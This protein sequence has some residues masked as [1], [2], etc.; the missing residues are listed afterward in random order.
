[1]ARQVHFYGGASLSNGSASITDAEISGYDGVRLDGVATATNFGTI[2][3]LGRGYYPSGGPAGVQLDGGGRLTNGSAIDRAALIHGYYGVLAQNDPATVINSGTIRGDVAA[4]VKLEAGGSLVNGALNN[5]AAL[6]EGYTGLSL[7][8]AGSASNFGT[9]L[10]LGEAGSFGAYLAGGESLINGAAALIYGFEGVGVAGTTATTVTN[11]GTIGGAGG[12]A[13]AFASVADFLI[14]EAGCAFDGAVLGAGGTLDLDT[15]TGTLAGAGSAAVTVTGSMA[16]TVFQGFHTLLVG[17]AA[18]FT[19]ATAVT[20]A[21]N[22]TIGDAGRLTLGGGGKNSIV[23][24]GTLQV[25]GSGTL[26]LAGAVTGAGRAIIDGGL[27]DCASSFNEAVTFTGKTGVLELAQSRTYTATVSGFSKT[28]GTSL[29]LDDIAFSKA[30]TAGYAGTKKRGVL[31]VT[32]GTHTANIH[33]KG[34][35]LNS[36]FV[37][38]GDGHG[39]AIVHDPAAPALS[40]PWAPAALA[41]RFV[42][43]LAGFEGSAVGSLGGAGAEP[44]RGAPPRL[45]AP[46]PRLS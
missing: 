35:Y 2:A 13:I 3:A 1:V 14:V 33:L 22:Q 4:G 12:T 30:T 28:G 46:Q 39:G 21:A 11:F 27:L 24:A 6:I 17:P 41:Q 25:G 36:T 5:H 8:G 19:Q 18:Q 37:V 9:I 45:A 31:T 16:P 44:W 20:I 32:D 43:A 10:G 38:S 40:P 42:A 23:N 26:I 7:A 29:D 34:N 15:G